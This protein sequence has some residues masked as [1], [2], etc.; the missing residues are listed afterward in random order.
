MRRAAGHD[1]ILFLAA[2]HSTVGGNRDLAGRASRGFR[3]LDVLVNNV[4]GTYPER[5]ETEDG[6]EA[7]LAANFLGP[8]VLTEE[9]LP[10]LRGGAP[11]RVVNV[12]SSA[13]GMWKCDP[14]GDLDA[15]ERYVGIEAY[16]REAP[17]HP[18]DVRACQEAR[19]IV[20]GRQRHQSWDGLDPRH[21][22]SHTRGR[23]VLAIRLAAG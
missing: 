6:Y 2:D 14:F 1:G 17:E 7:T 11:S 15:E 16:A 9:L 12:V 19:R 23:A 20:R 18:L 3:R 5:G 4:G 10:L 22:V 8:S 21:P 13:H